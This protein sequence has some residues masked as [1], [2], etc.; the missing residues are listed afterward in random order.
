MGANAILMT[1][2]GRGKAAWRADSNGTAGNPISNIAGTE[3]GVTVRGANS[4]NTTDVTDATADITNNHIQGIVSVSAQAIVFAA[5]FLTTTTDAPHLKGTISNNVISGQD[6]EGI[7]ALATPGSSAS[8]DVDIHHNTVSAPN[9][10]GCNRFGITAQVG[11][12]SANT[13]GNPAM[14]LNIHDNT[15]AGS[16]VNTGI[17]IRKKTASYVF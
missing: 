3:I 16:G 6:G 11:T 14:C 5:D 4:N 10:G 12:S 15:A 17:G 9:C 8:V 2:T 13:T 7:T 1:L